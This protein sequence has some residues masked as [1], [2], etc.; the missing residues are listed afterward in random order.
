MGPNFQFTDEL[1]IWMVRWKLKT[2]DAKI[3]TNIETTLIQF[4]SQFI[5]VFQKFC[6]VRLG[7]I[8]FG[9][10]V[11]NRNTPKIKPMYVCGLTLKNHQFSTFPKTFIELFH[12]NSS[13]Q[14]YEMHVL[15]L[16]FQLNGCVLLEICNKYNFSAWVWMCVCAIMFMSSYLL[17]VFWKSM[18]RF[19]L[20]A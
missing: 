8:Y 14:F 9:I 18:N 7:F 16:Q 2:I 20:I 6:C 19:W 1:N 17:R 10:A 5:F 12:A 13:F 3:R 4:G 15:T 11:W